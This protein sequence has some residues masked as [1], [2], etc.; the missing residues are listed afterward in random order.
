MSRRAK[1]GPSFEV[2]IKMAIPLLQ[3]AERQCP[4]NGP[5]AKPKIKDWVVGALIMIG[6]LAR[7]KTK[8][9]Q[10][11]FLRGRQRQIARWLG[12]AD[13]PS[14][15][16]YF[17]RYRRSYPLYRMAVRLQGEQAMAEGITNPMQV[18]VDKSLVAAHGPPWHQRDRHAGKIPAG[19][20]REAAWGYSEHDG[21][22]YGYSYEVVVSSTPGTIVFPLLGSADTASAC[23]TQTFIAKIDDLSPMILFVSADAAYDA[24]HLGERIEYDTQGQRTKRH[25]LCP[26]NPRNAGRPRRKK[27]WVDAN[28][29]R[30]RERRRQRRSYLESPKGHRLYARRKKT[31]EP[32]NQWFKSLFELDNRVWHRGLNNNQ[33][34]FLAA[35]FAY[36]LLVRYNYCYG[37]KNGQLCWI[38]DRL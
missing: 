20:D 24:N 2:L 27:G 37:N 22:V 34:Q 1:E 18:S 21:W 38:I 11:R 33:T 29:M 5:G 3:E 4:R 35:I 15:S 28:Q 36:Q 12:T 30:S 26:E 17:R 16:G 32:F 9:A 23:E 10:Y 19:V 7:R 8:S 31:V 14:R 25:F 13:F 6:I